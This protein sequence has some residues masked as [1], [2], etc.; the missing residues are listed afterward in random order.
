VLLAALGLAAPASAAPVPVSAVNWDLF[1]RSV[2][3]LQK[4]RGDCLDVRQDDYRWGQFLGR[5][6]FRYTTVFEGVGLPVDGSFDAATGTGSIAGT[7]I[8]IRV[9][10]YNAHSRAIRIGALGLKVSGGKGTL[11]GRIERTRT[12]FSRFGP[13]RPLL[14]L[15]G[16]TAVSGPFQ[17]KGKDVPDTFVI[18]VQGSATLL[19]ALAREL[20]RI[21]CTGPHIVTSHPIRA[22]ISFGAVR[23]QLRPNAAV[24]LGGTFEIAGLEAS[25][26]DP[27]ADQDV[28]VTVAPTAPARQAG[29]AIHWDLPADLRTPLHCEASYNCVPAVGA[30]FA[31]AGGFVLSA[32]GRSTTV[33]NLAVASE[34]V[35]G[36]PAPVVTGTLDGAPITVMH[37][38]GTT[39]E[40]D[41]RVSAALQISGLRIN[42]GGIFAHFAKTVPP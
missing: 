31:L 16:V 1:M 32:G 5:Y 42:V 24:G 37:G 23:A 18:A 14:R 9:D 6:P 41:D 36:S 26:Y 15:T 20:T 30:Q 4:L 27:V 11:T 22:G 8:A 13:A 7:G 34:D 35:N 10:N 17:R 19:P 29:K 2:G 38:G 28:T 33:A 3:F 21:R 12:I 39:S 40:F 25:G